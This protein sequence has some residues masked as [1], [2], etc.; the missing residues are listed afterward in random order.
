[1]Y[2]VETKTLRNALIWTDYL[3]ILAVFLLHTLG[4]VV[5]SYIF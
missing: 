2:R 4:S 1:M 5:V 3:V